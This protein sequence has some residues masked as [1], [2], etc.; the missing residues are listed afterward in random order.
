[1][2]D[3]PESGN[4]NG[5]DETTATETAS[6][7]PEAPVPAPVAEPVEDP[8]PS[9]EELEALYTDASELYG[10]LWKISRGK[11]PGSIE[12]VDQTKGLI[13][14]IQDALLASL[15][16][17]EQF[18]RIWKSEQGC[19]SDALKLKENEVLLRNLAD[20]QDDLI[21][22]LGFMDE[23]FQQAIDNNNIV[24]LLET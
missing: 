6:E 4:E 20:V 9:A 8:G 23:A 17:S 19:L 1:M 15:D 24:A 5:S 7:T 13:M 14:K 18:R 2:A 11:A 16:D 21:R 10:S 3:I 12:I 22:T